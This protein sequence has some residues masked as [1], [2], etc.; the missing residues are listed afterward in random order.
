MA[1]YSVNEKKMANKITY[2]DVTKAE[3]GEEW[4]PL[5]GKRFWV[6]LYYGDSPVVH[7]GHVLD[8]DDVECR[9]VDDNLV[10][11]EYVEASNELTEDEAGFVRALMSGVGE[12]ID[13]AAVGRAIGEALASDIPETLKTS[14]IKKA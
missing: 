3:Y 13:I 9:D 2:T 10:K 12:I 5:G 1:T 7:E 4:S 14:G 6:R 8:I 11:W